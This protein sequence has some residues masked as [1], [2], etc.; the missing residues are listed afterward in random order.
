MKCIDENSVFIVAVNLKKY[1]GDTY[2]E[3]DHALCISGYVIDSDGELYVQV[4]DS[5]LGVYFMM[6][7]DL[8]T[9]ID[10]N[11]YGFKE[12]YALVSKRSKVASEV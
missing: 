4:I 3:H 6:F 7:K 9:I 2:G 1:T 11:P 10:R 12:G 8:Q 5:R